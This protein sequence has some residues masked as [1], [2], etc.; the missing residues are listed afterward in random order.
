V[1]RKPFLLP[2]LLLLAAVDVASGQAVVRRDSTSVA[3]NWFG[4]WS[5]RAS[6]GLTLVGTWTAIPDATN[7]T[8][9]GT[10]TLANAQGNEVASGAWSAAKSPERWTGGWRA[11]IA[12]RAG[13]FAGTWTAAGDVAV[14]GSFVDLFEKAVENIVSGTWQ[15]VGRSGAWSIR[16]RKAEGGA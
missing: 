1:L 6:S 12:G 11:V 13:E 3:Q 14:K 2:C 16:A 5:A 8:V 15:G 4:T 10:W 7:G 9:T